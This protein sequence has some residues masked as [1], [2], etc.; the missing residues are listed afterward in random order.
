M[1]NIDIDKKNK[2]IK[3]RLGFCVLFNEKSYA[4]SSQIENLRVFMINNSD[5]F[6]NE[7]KIVINTILG[8]LDYINS[9]FLSNNDI[10]LSIIDK[11]EKF[12]DYISYIDNK[13]TV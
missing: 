3:N 2:L 6:N 1:K 9:V 12:C 8:Q 13:K 10:L 7:N 11:N 4:I 5:L